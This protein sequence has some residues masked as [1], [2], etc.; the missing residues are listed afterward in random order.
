MR[1][2][3]PVPVNV[4]R[5]RGPGPVCGRTKAIRVVSAQGREKRQVKRPECALLIDLSRTQETVRA[6]GLRRASA[7]AGERGLTRD[8]RTSSWLLRQEAEL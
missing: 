2:V 6:A 4:R 1:A 5:L 7:C 3:A 8:R